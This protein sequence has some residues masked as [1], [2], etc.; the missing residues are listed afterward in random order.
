VLAGKPR[1][2]PKLHRHRA[3]GGCYPRGPTFLCQRKTCK[4]KPCRAG[5]GGAAH[6]TQEAPRLWTYGRCAD[7]HRR[8]PWTTLARCP[9]P[10]PSPTCPQPSTTMRSK[11]PEPQYRGRPS[12]RHRIPELAGHRIQSR[13]AGEMRFKEKDNT[14]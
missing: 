2:E 10:A 3:R 6:S 9:P 12:L 13:P 14:R 11:R 8:G 7:A 4:L 5:E 1:I